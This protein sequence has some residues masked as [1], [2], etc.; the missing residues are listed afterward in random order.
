MNAQSVQVIFHDHR[1]HPPL[2][3]PFR[4]VVGRRRVRVEALTEFSLPV[5]AKL[6]NHSLGQ[7]A[8]L[9]DLVLGFDV[10]RLLGKLRQALIQLGD[11]GFF[12][13]NLDCGFRPIRRHAEIVVDRRGQQ[14]RD[15]YPENG[16]TPTMDEWPVVAQGELPRRFRLLE[17]PG[18][19]RDLSR[20]SPIRDRSG[21]RRPGAQW[22]KLCI[23]GRRFTAASPHFSL[24][25][26]RST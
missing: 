13:V 20:G 23:H 9:E 3:V 17:R 7:G 16:P 24:A 10:I 12:A 11:I 4:L 8:T 14:R 5:K 18:R 2:R 21:R 19:R 1:M 15:D 25:D 6:R 26:G 22:L